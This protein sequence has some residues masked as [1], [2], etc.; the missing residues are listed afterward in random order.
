MKI[1]NVCDFHQ[2]AIQMKLWINWRNLSSKIWEPLSTFWEIHLAEL[3]AFWKKIWTCITLPAYSFTACWVR[4]RSS[5]MSV[6]AR[7]FRKASKTQ[8]LFE[9]NHSDKMWFYRYSRKSS[10]SSQ[11]KRPS[12][13]H[14][15]M[16]RQVHYFFL[17]HRAVQYEF[18]PWGQTVNQQFYI[19]TPY[20]ICEKACGEND[21]IL[22]IQGSAFFYHDN[23]LDQW[24]GG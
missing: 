19:K 21:L 14:P 5:V 17:I 15:K 9:D 8:I 6:F 4:S 2:W 7:T 3:R 1:L 13:P 16:T 20:G 24:I 12:S 22:V 18:V 11:Q 10:K 23:A